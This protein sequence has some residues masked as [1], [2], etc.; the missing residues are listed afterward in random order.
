MHGLGPAGTL[1][2]LPI[3]CVALAS[4]CR[5]LSQQNGDNDGHFGLTAISD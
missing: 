5:V 1:T 4:F 3:S 2:P